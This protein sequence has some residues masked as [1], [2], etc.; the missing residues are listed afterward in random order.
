M[1]PG[2]AFRGLYNG[3]CH[4]PRM[5]RDM[6]CI[7]GPDKLRRQQTVG[8]GAEGASARMDHRRIMAFTVVIRVLF[9]FFKRSGGECCACHW[10]SSFRHCGPGMCAG[11]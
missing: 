11:S 6:K 2:G 3:M 10:K 9:C 1:G 5:I 8:Q 4:F 7:Q